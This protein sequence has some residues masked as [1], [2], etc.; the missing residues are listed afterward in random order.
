M[1]LESPG[2]APGVRSNTGGSGGQTTVALMWRCGTSTT[3]TGSM[4]KETTSLSLLQEESTQ[5]MF[6]L[7][8]QMLPLSMEKLTFFVK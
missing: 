3:F 2:V 4:K 5:L 8:Y 6:Q 1:K 7:D